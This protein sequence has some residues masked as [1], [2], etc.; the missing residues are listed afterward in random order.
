VQLPVR[1]RYPTR[2]GKEMHGLP[3]SCSDV[4]QR[5]TAGWPTGGDAY[6]HGAPIVVVGVT[7]HQGARESLVQG[8]AP[9]EAQET[10]PLVNGTTGVTS[11][12]QHLTWTRKGEGTVAWCQKAGDA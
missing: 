12:I 5:R 11:L 8:G 2:I 3:T 1:E 6:G 7:P 4:R 9:C 10:F